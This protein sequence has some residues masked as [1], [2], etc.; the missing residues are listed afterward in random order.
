MR[1]LKIALIGYGKMGK[2]VE[3]M[4]ISAGNEIV[5]K[6]DSPKDWLEQADNFQKADVAIDFSTPLVVVD[7]IEHCF[8]AHKP[9]VV[10]T[11]G[12]QDRLTYFKN[13]AETEKQSFFY[14]SN[15]SIGVS[16]FG[17]LVRFLSHAMDTQ[18]QYTCQIEETHHI[19]KLDKPSGTA[20]TIAQLVLEEMKR[21]A[22]WKLDPSTTELSIA[23]N[24]QTI[25]I[26]SKRE[27]AVVGT[28]MVSFDSKEDNIQIIHTAK[29]REGFALGAVRAAEWLMGKAGCFTM[30]DMLGF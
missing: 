17:S 8:S 13:K 26:H 16:V 27:G 11:T 9:I 14:A 20:V 2:E 25:P 12:W 3:K 24:M 15:F 4:A 22:D 7:N 30:K 1:S 28:H 21:Y 19:H 6:I 29:S 18:E 10:G 5:C 23:A